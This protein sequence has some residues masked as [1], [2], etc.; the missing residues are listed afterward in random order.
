MKKNITQG[1]LL[2]A[3]RLAVGC[4]DDATTPMM[5]GNGDGGVT[6]CP[7]EVSVSGDITEDTTWSCSAYLLTGKIFVTNNAV[8]T[9]NPGTQIFGDTNSAEEAALI[10]TRGAQLVARGTADAPIVFTSGN[11]EGSR[12]TGDWAGV[13][14]LGSARVNSGSCAGDPDTATEACEQPGH[15]ESHLEGIDVADARGV[16]G[17][18]DD[19][20]NCGALEYVRVEFAGAELS[21]DN[22]LNGITVAGCGSA[23]ELS[24]L[25]VHRGKDDGIEFFGGTAG[26]DHVIIWARRTTV[27]TG[28]SAG[29]VRFSSSSFTSSRAPA[30]T[31]SK[32]T[33]SAQTKTRSPAAI[34]RS[35]TPR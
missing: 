1:L 27:S 12:T 20:S 3:I 28:T 26:M 17:G 18:A 6:E 25:Q 11:P 2:S 22:E 34:R 4:G 21:P 14:L 5:M 7:A 9:I 15:F 16:F 30:T 19:A 24:Y 8:L 32:P 31:R 23:T 33:T 35:S 29:R 10:V 13:A